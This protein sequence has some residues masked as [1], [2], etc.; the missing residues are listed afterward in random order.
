M[1]TIPATQQASDQFDCLA[2]VAIPFVFGPAVG[3]KSAIGGSDASK[4]PLEVIS[5]RLEQKAPE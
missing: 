4:T 1:S 3:T 5:L 2:Y